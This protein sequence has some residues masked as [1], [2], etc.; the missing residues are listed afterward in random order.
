MAKINRRKWIK[1]NTYAALALA[2]PG[3]ITSSFY[4]SK[5]MNIIHPICA[6]CGV[7][8]ESSTQEH[9]PVCEDSR[10]YVNADGQKWTT[11]AALNKTHK[12]IIEKVAPNIYAIYTNPR[13]GI[14]QH[15]HLVIT[16]H[17]NILW[18]CIANLDAT[19]IDIVRKLGGIKAIAISHPHYYST[20]MEWSEAFDHA[21]IYIHHS[22]EEWVQRKGEAVQLWKG[23]EKELWNGMK[24]VLC[25]GHFDGATVLYIPDHGGQLLTGDIPLVCSDRKT[26]TFMY[27]YPNYIPLPPKAIRYIKESLDPLVYDS[28]FGAFGTY[29]EQNG[30]KAVDFSISRYLDQIK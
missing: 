16:P 7:Q 5:E 17:G 22:D 25:A 20:M 2:I 6:T 4:K 14:G 1:Q 24:L 8:Y 21:P 26:V 13:F 19:T 11:L 23:R 9:C 27:S 12:N 28:V 29:I 10:Q 15:A 18:D 30:K 3:S